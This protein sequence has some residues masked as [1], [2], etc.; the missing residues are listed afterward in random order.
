MIHL[1][2]AWIWTFFNF[3]SILLNG[4]GFSG[5]SSINA[6]YV[7]DGG[8]QVLISLEKKTNFSIFFELA[9]LTLILFHIHFLDHYNDIFDYWTNGVSIS[10]IITKSSTFQKLKIKSSTLLE[11]F[12]NAFPFTKLA[13]RKNHKK[14]MNSSWKYPDI[15]FQTVRLYSFDFWRYIHQQLN[16]KRTSLKLIQSPYMPTFFRNQRV[17]EMKP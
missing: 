15:I 10:Q 14:V 4:L 11:C 13:R 17:Y 12:A 8:T 9:I 2:A 6:Y 7:T 5:R 16:I 3:S 1:W